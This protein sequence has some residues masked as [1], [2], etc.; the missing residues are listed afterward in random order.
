VPFTDALRVISR[1][2]SGAKDLLAAMNRGATRG[3]RANLFGA[4]PA[5]NEK[6]ESAVTGL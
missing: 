3:D 4:A 6:A 2:G 1:W 5:A